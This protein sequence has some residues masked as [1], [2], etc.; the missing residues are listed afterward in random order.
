MNAQRRFHF[1]FGVLMG[2]S[3][4]DC[5]IQ[6]IRGTVMRVRG[7][8]CNWGGWTERIRRAKGAIVGQRKTEFQLC[9]CAMEGIFIVSSHVSSTLVMQWRRETWGVDT[10]CRW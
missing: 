8:S 6:L 7:F 9:L 10:I 3:F 4:N 2:T 5:N 1:Q